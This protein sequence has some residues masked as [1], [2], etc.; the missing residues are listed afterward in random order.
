MRIFLLLLV[1]IL[2]LLA[3]IPTLYFCLFY[4]VHNVATTSR[5]TFLSSFT[6]STFSF[7]TSIPPSFTVL[8]SPFAFSTFSH[9]FLLYLL[10]LHSSFYLARYTTRG[11]RLRNPIRLTAFF[12]SLSFCIFLLSFLLFYFSTLTTFTFTT[13]KYK[14]YEASIKSS[15]FPR[16]HCQT[17]SFPYTLP[18]ILA[19]GCLF[20]SPEQ[21]TYILWFVST[22]HV[23]NALRP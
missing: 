14:I 5:P 11:K 8:L 19:L 12:C 16:P 4:F 18:S 6:I 10:S 13:S 9:F 3:D 23:I 21:K 2:L 1:I 17:D 20:K 15:S 22:V 7:F